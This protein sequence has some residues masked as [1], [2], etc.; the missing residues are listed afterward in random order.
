MFKQKGL[1]LIELMVSLVIGLVLMTGVV[2]VFISS[3]G[4]FTTQNAMSRVQEVGRLAIDF[5]AKDI[6]Q[7]GYAGCITRGEMEI[8]D[9]L[10]ASASSDYRYS[11]VNAIRGYDA[12]TAE[13]TL[14]VTD[15]LTGIEVKANTDALFVSSAGASSLSLSQSTGSTN[16]VKANGA[17]SGGCVG[18][19]CEGDIVVLSDCVQARRFQVT[20]LTENSGKVDVKYDDSSATPGNNTASWG[21]EFDTGSQIIRT[22][23]MLYFIADNEFGEPSLYQKVGDDLPIVLLEGVQDMKLTYS[24]NGGA[25]VEDSAVTNWNAV[26]SVNVELL[27][28]S[29]VDNVIEDSQPYTFAGTTTTPADRRIRQTFNSTIAIRNRLQ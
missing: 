24:S 17:V 18:D 26:T 9:G 29:P 15:G 28:R 10:D 6:R 5:M 12:D 14:N 3:K 23:N 1:S 8:V 25:Y 2:E 13:N 21:Q 20:G 4:T 27:V 11:F 22:T 7:A 19:V 16:T